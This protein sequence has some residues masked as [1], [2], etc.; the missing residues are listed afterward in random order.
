MMQLQVHLEHEQLVVFDAD[1]PETLRPSKD[2][3]LSAYFTATQE[4]P[5]ARNILYP[6]FPSKFTWHSNL[7]QWLPRKTRKT[8]GHMVFIPSNAGENFYA[9][10][11]LSKVP[12]LCCFHDLKTVDGVVYPS[13][14]EACLARG[15]L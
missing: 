9:R 6:D 10:L 4:Y 3:H 11:I 12:G 8:S 1:S 15:F 2:T 13:I 7:A 14:R 5:E